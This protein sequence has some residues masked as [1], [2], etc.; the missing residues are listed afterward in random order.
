MKSGLDTFSVC[1]NMIKIKYVDFDKTFNATGFLTPL[2]KVNV[3]IN[4]E[5]VLKNLSATKDLERRVFD[6]HNFPNIM[7]SNILNLAA[8]YR[9]FFRGN[10]L[11]TRVFIYHTDFFSE[12]F[13]EMKYNE[14]YRAYYINKYSRNPKYVLMGEILQKEVF[15][16]VK[17]IMDF[18]N[19]VYLISAKNIEGSLIPYIIGAADP[20]R[21][22]IIIS[23]D[24][25]ETQY[26][27]NI[28]NSFYLLRRN[29]E[30]L[31]TRYT[32]KSYLEYLIRKTSDDSNYDLELSYYTNKAFYILLL[33]CIGDK[34][35][36]L[37]GIPNLKNSSLIKLINKGIVEHKITN[38]TT[39]F[40]V[41][42]EIFP[43]IFQ[44]SIE[45]NFHVL[46]FDEMYRDL[47]KEQKYT[48][49]S[50]MVDRF[51]HNSLLKLNST[52]FYEYPM[53]LEAL[54]M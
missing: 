5:T 17:T 9:R 52:E 4:L 19:G 11:D 43:D 47:T 21:K 27:D 16:K 2:D 3:F 40:D 33:A 23:S 49:T 37:D 22:N 39:Q 29:S 32:Q 13:N 51:D 46:N 14:D 35:R 18:I 30:G 31:E 34:Y 26:T 10:G 6:S 41:L 7:V 20:S 45:S 15:P 24:I 50:Q 42:R 12:E 25:V 36:S 1:F 48:I 28:R 54:T 44:E 8:H 53:M 38:M